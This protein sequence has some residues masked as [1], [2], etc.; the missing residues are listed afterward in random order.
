MAKD[1]LFFR[2][3]GDIHPVT[4]VP[5]IAIILQGVV[6]IVIAVSGKYE[7]ILSYVVSIDFVFFGLTGAALFIFRKRDRTDAD[8]KAPGHPLTTAL[9][10]IACWVVVAATIARSPQQSAIGFAILLAGVP[11]FLM[12]RRTKTA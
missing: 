12:W 9:F 10:T 8:F 2:S 6:A 7:Q 3:V 1:G 11:A 5:I 4:R